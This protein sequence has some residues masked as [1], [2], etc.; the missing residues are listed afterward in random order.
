VGWGRKEE[1]AAK[2]TKHLF[3]FQREQNSPA[4]LKMAKKFYCHLISTM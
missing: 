2:S 1:K 3:Y 4:R